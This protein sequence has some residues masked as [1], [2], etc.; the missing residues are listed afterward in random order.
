MFIRKKE[1]EIDL[2]DML[3]ILEIL[4]SRLTSLCRRMVEGDVHQVLMKYPHVE[5]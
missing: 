2:H 1:D 4:N 5:R 3:S